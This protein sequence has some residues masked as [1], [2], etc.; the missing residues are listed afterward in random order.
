MTI[1]A[2][3]TNA[4]DGASG[5]GTAYIEVLRNG[6]RT[7]LTSII[8]FTTTGGSPTTIT[9]SSSYKILLSL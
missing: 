3:L 5:T 1:T 4:G 9:L 2:S 7:Q 6:V 8:G